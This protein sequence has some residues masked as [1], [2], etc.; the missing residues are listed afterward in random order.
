METH[1]C[2]IKI[3]K[4]EEI[5]PFIPALAQ[6]RMAV[7]RDYPY[8]YEGSKEYEENYLRVYLKSK[9]TII[10]LV[11][12]GEKVVGASSGMP[13]K[14]EDNAV[15]KPFIDADINLED[16]FYFGESVLLKEYRGY[17]FGKRF[18]YEREKHAKSLNYKIA[19]FC[20]VVRPEN[21]PQKPKDYHPLDLFW[22]KKGYKKME[23]M[24]THFSWQDIGDESE[25]PKMMQFWMKSLSY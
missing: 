8:L 16:V 14:L 20:G 4:G 12:D 13:L 25:T 15:K 22:E 23:G 5:V 9:D 21:H 3:V 10:V 17:G 6:L 24:Q 11:R 7:F 19:A 2:D 18:F 1:N